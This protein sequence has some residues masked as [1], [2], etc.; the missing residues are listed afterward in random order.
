MRRTSGRVGAALIAVLLAAAC[1]GDGSQRDSQAVFIENPL[2]AAA[3]A[4]AEAATARVSMTMEMSL[5]G[6]GDPVSMVAQGVVDN[7]A[8][9]S[10]LEIDM[11]EMFEAFGGAPGVDQDDLVFEARMVDG[12]VYMRFPAAFGAPTEWVSMDVLAAAEDAG[13]STSALG[14]LG[15]SDPTQYLDYLASVSRDVREIGAEDVRGVATTHYAATLDFAS[16]PEDFDAEVLAE[17]GIDRDDLAASFEAMRDQ[18]GV[19]NVPVDVWIDG[20]GLVR[21]MRM[22]MGLDPADGQV[23]A[24]KMRVELEMFDYGVEVRVEAPPADEVTDLLER[25][26]GGVAS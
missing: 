2:A 9:T 23:P 14:Q 8:Q 1:G 16:A 6:F 13:L 15:G 25:A 24:M 19:A 12:I 11:T 20:E 7:A 21:R 26:G 10:Q 17:L 22:S 18:F 5:P 3:V 4:T